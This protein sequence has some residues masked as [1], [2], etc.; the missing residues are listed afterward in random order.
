MAMSS[1]TLLR[2]YSL[3]WILRGDGEAM[4]VWTGYVFAIVLVGL[5]LALRVAILPA[6]GGY[7]FLTFYPAV[8]ATALL[9]GAGPALL[10]LALSA[11]IAE[12]AFMPPFWSFV[13]R[14]DQ[15][16]PLAVFIAAGGLTCALA[17]ELQRAASELRESGEA[18]RAINK[19]V[20]ASDAALRTTEQRL[21]T[22]TKSVPAM[23]GYWN[24]ELRCEF[25][26]DAYFEWFGLPP[27][28]VIGMTLRALL[29]EDLFRLNEP[30]ALAA[31]AGRA[32]RFERMLVKPDGKRG[33]TDASYVPDIDASGI[34]HG[35]FV[36][37]ADV[38]PSH[39]SYER[40]RELA[41]RLETAREQERRSIALALHEGIAQDL[42]AARLTIDQLKSRWRDVPGVAQACDEISD[43][44]VK[45]VAETRQVA[46]DLRPSALPH[47]SLLATLKAHARFFGERSG[48]HIEV[49]EIAPFPALPEATALLYFRAAQELLSNVARHARAKKVGIVLRADAE[50]ITMQISDDGVGIADGA[51]D[52]PGSLGL[53]G[54][55]ERFAVLGGTLCVQR[56]A[57]A[58]TVVTIDLPAGSLA[59]QEL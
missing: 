5:A 29:G 50:H 46:N 1:R 51:V 35:F 14:E 53:L 26:N 15:V 4:P 28:R 21:R 31:L 6:G 16:V 57:S 59:V 43:A 49:A 18:L 56:G 25:A 30:Y 19:R 58:G 55:R 45:C 41:R 54:I 23:I 44:L 33:F 9:L 52:K 8:V 40:I 17:Y 3:T 20:L 39:E 32:Q 27:E 42:F 7:A 36:L 37:V 34:V 38:T 2:R 22:V 24:R 11:C 10:A 12:Y 13:L 48:L 47:S